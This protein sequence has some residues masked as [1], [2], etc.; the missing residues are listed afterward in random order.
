[1]KKALIVVDFQNDFVNGS[2]GFSGAEKLDDIIESKIKKYLDNNADILF[3]LDTHYDNYLETDE[4]KRLPVI[5]CIEDTNGHNVY[6]RVNNYL[7]NAKKV[8]K[9]NTFGSLELGNY[10]KNQKYDLIEIVGLVTNMCVISNAV[11]AKAALPDVSIIIDQKAVMS[12]DNDL[13]LKTL[14]VLKGMHVDII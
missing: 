8:F 1:M 3:T 2:L 11:I 14:D 13:H 9:K 6:G 5:H 4:G 12:F 7:K 10:L